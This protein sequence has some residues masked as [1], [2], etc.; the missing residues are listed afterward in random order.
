MISRSALKDRGRVAHRVFTFKS[1]KTAMLSIHRVFTRGSRPHARHDLDVG[2]TTAVSRFLVTIVGSAQARS[3]AI[4]SPPKTPKATW[5]FGLG[6]TQA[7]TFSH[8]GGFSQHRVRVYD[9]NFPAIEYCS[10]FFVSHN[11]PSHADSI[12]VPRGNTGTTV[13]AVVEVTQF[14]VTMTIVATDSTDISLVTP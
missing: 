9:K 6:N 14:D 3:C 13:D 12:S 10:H 11:S 1:S 2:R 8:S 5:T 7:V 4:T